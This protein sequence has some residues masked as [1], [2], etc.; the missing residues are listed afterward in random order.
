MSDFTINDRSSGTVPT[1][2]TIAFVY[3]E[4]TNVVSLPNYNDRN[5]GINL[6]FGTRL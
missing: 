6:E 5:L 4:E 2:V 3:R 1:L